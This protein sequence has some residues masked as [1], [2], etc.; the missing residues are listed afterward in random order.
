[1]PN[2]N[3]SQPPDTLTLTDEEEA[4][5]TAQYGNLDD[6]WWG[7]AEVIARATI[8]GDRPTVVCRIPPW[9]SLGTYIAMNGVHDGIRKF[10]GR[11]WDPPELQDAVDS[12]LSIAEQ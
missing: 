6:A 7:E 8:S 10:W 4:T 3:Q 1:M 12:A 2:P 5:L 9:G 11:A